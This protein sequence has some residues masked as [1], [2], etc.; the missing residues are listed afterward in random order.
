MIPK[1]MKTGRRQV[2]TCC[3]RT[4]SLRSDLCTNV[5]EMRLMLNVLSVQYLAAREC[6]KMFV[7]T[8]LNECNIFFYI[9]PQCERRRTLRRHLRA[10]EKKNT[11]TQGANRVNFPAREAYCCYISIDHYISVNT[12]S[13][14]FL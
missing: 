7:D 9:F 2:V 12:L 8:Q 1:A 3:S 14:L 10:S 5:S 6:V 4:F 13:L 11:Y